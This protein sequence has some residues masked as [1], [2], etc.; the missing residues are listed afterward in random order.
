MVIRNSF[1]EMRTNDLD[2]QIHRRARALSDSWLQESGKAEAASEVSTD[3][4][5]Q[6][7]ATLSSDSEFLAEEYESSTVMGSEDGVERW[8]DSASDS[9][10]ESECLRSRASSVVGPPGTWAGTLPAPVVFVPLQA[11]CQA[12]ETEQP[13]EANWGSRRRRRG[14]RG[15]QKRH[16][17]EDNNDFDLE[18]SN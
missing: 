5:R 14:C 11:A 3:D 17:N 18:L 15:G 6:S 12:T 4:E 7:W 13:S 2:V 10:E 1:W 9:E 16:R 8:A